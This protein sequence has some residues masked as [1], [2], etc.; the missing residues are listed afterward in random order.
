MNQLSRKRV[1]FICIGNA[2][3]S[4]MAESIARR[5]AADVM[6]ASS[7]G[8]SPL[9]FIARQTSRTL[10]ANGYP[11]EGLQSKPIS[12][13]EWDSADVIVNM[14]G[15]SSQYAF[16]RFGPPGAGV[17][18][19]IEDWPVE[20]PYGCDEQFYQ[21]VLEDI[22]ERIAGLARRLAASAEPAGASREA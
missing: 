3:R 22:Q 13:E 16:A 18:P 14:S 17:D 10:E 21:E 12:Q 9:G 8:I 5:D 2:C 4:P 11:T 19:R 6:E 15:W 20:D 1:L 7:A